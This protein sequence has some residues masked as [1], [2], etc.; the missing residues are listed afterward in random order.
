MCQSSNTLQ[1]G[2]KDIQNQRLKQCLPHIDISGYY[3]SIL[4]VKQ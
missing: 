1:V 2:R 4:M 3:L